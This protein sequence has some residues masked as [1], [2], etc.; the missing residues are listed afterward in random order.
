MAVPVVREV[1][2]DALYR[3]SEH[4]L[5]LRY[6]GDGRFTVMRGSSTTTIHRDHLTFLRAPVKVIAAVDELLEVLS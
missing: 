1:P 5:V 4:V 6:E 3:G 2:K